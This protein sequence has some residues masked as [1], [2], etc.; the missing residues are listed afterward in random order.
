[1]PGLEEL[2]ELLARAILVPLA[3]AFDDLEQLI[4]GFLSLA[5]GVECRGEIETRLMIQRISG[6]LLFELADRSE[7]LRLFGKIDRRLHCRDR[8]I[9]AL[10]FR[11]LGERLAGLLDRAG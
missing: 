9:A 6:D 3:V 1:A 10:G 2:H 4:G 5:R 8:G 7:R 11:D